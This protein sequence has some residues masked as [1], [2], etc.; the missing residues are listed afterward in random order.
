MGKNFSDAVEQAL[1]YIYYEARLGKGAEGLELLKKA[2]EEGDGDASCILARCMWGPQYVWSGHNF[3]EDDDLGTEYLHK[4]VEQG[5]ALGVMV[6][7]RCGEF[8]QAMAQKMPFADLKEVFHKVLEMAEAGNAFC[9]YP[10]GNYY[11]WGDFLDVDGINSNSFSSNAELM[12]Y[13]SGNTKK[14]EEW[15]WKALKGGVYFAVS[16]LRSYYIKGVSDY[17]APQPEKAKDLFKIGAEMGHPY[18]QWSY[19]EELEKQGKEQEGFEWRKKAAEGG[20]TECWYDVAEQYRIGKYLPKD[21]AKAAEC[22]EKCVYQKEDNFSKLVSSNR[23]GIMYCEG[24]GVEQDYHKALPLMKIAVE[25][26]YPNNLYYLGKC[27]YGVGEY[28]KARECFENCRTYDMEVNYMWGMMYIQGLG[29]KE[30]IGK[31]IKLLKEA[32]GIP[33]AKEEIA[34]YKKPLF[35]KWVRK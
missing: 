24:D 20:Q 14:C 21:L 1:R 16:N 10:I 6:A 5:S 34:K 19:A 26:K 9:Q 8:S 17:V 13:V 28:E 33:A 32:K 27:Y 7:M 11:F 29:V 31:G 4:S 23:L 12:A 30:N 25:K 3:P 2:S 35:G 18:W 22:Y 15:F